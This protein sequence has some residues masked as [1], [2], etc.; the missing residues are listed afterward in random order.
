H[1][2][3]GAPIIPDFL[4]ARVTRHAFLRDY[5][6]DGWPDIA[7]LNDGSSNVS[8]FYVNA[9]S[10]GAF[11]H[12]ALAAGHLPAGAAA[13]AGNAAATADIDGALGLDL[14]LANGPNSAQ[15][16]LWLND[17]AGFFVDVTAA[18]MPAETTSETDVQIGDVNGDGKPDMLFSEWVEAPAEVNR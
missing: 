7:V 8:Q 9:Q 13:R 6:N 15:N 14:V 1:E 4:T 16:R 11:D 2:V 18:Q 12:F 10:G 3:T 17:G 5:T